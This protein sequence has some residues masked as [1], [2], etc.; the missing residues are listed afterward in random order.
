MRMLFRRGD[1][2]LSMGDCCA[3]LAMTGYGDLVLVSTGV[4]VIVAVGVGLT[5]SSD[6][7]TKSKKNAF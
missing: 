2:L 4:F 6:C 5:Y 3:S 1:L 7:T